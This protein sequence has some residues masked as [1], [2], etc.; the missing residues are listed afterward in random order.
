MFNGYSWQTR[1][2]EVRP[3]RL[4]ASPDPDPQ[5][6]QSAMSSHAQLPPLNGHVNGLHDLEKS[7][8][9]SDLL[10]GNTGMRS[11]FVGN[12][13]L[14]LIHNCL[15]IFFLYDQLTLAHISA[16]TTHSSLSISNGK[17]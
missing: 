15:T 4:G 16:H 2:L 17:I 3:D 7:L 12:V 13:R 6:A 10:T 8:S 11:L 1:V 14:S 9:N 5:L